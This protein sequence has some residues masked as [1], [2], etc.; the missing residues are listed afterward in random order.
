M[1]SLREMTGGR[2]PDACIE[3]V[4]MEAHGTGPMYALDRAKQALHL[5]SD[6]GSAL[7]EAAMP[8]ARAACCRSS[9][10]TASS[11]SSRSAS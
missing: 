5:H 9:A 4:G 11:T 7:R 8:S 2:G 10:S 1:E 3:A 6:R